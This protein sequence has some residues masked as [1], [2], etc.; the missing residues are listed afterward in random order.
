MRDY[1]NEGASVGEAGPS[2]SVRT[3]AANPPRRRPNAPQ[4][5]SD[6]PQPSRRADAMRDTSDTRRADDT[7][8]TS[9]RS[10]TRRATDTRRTSS[11]APQNPN[12]RRR[13]TRRRQ[14][15][16]ELQRV[17]MV[18]TISVALL[19]AL[20]VVPALFSWDT[21]AGT[22]P[23]SDALTRSPRSEDSEAVEL[24]AAGINPELAPPAEWNPETAP[25]VEDEPAEQTPNTVSVG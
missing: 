22:L 2:G 10:A 24:N 3:I 25:P 1:P 13:P 23:L 6:A 7:R 14:A 8:D 18:V 19:L 16:T 5:Q 15:R 17:E 21:R 12:V 11:D 20:F 9:R 4:G